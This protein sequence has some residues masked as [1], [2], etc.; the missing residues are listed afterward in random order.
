MESTQSIP[1][2]CRLPGCQE[3][4]SS[5]SHLAGAVI[6][7]FLGALLLRRGAGDRLRLAFLGVYAASCV[8]LFAMSGLY[9]MMARGELARQIFERLD[10]CAI[11]L[12]VAGTF[13]P[14]HGIL[15]RGWLR[16]GPLLLIWFGAIAGVILKMI[17]FKELA[18]WL[19]LSL[20]L[21]LGWL[22]IFGAV[23]LARQYGLAYIKPILLGGVAYTLG[24]LMD[25]RGWPIFIPG[26]IHPHDVFHIAVLLGALFHWRFIWDI[27]NIN[28]VA[29]N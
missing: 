15:F 17:Y 21:G 12:L 6:F 19:G 3:P 20:Y 18:D 10:H 25:L 7:V 8:L 29:I 1:E 13:T 22:G 5:L 27:S 9:H 2:I 4:F 23:L 26:W 16:W 28:R 24:G 14:I 11:F